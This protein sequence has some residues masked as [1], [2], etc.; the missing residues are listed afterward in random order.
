MKCLLSFA[1]RDVAL[2][3]LCARQSQETE[4]A[5][6][7]SQ[8]RAFMAREDTA[9]EYLSQWKGVAK[10]VL[11]HLLEDKTISVKDTGLVRDT[12]ADINNAGVFNSSKSDTLTEEQISE[13]HALEG[14]IIA[15]FLE[16]YNSIRTRTPP[17]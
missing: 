8:L 6:T 4:A 13:I 7:L 9:R 14:N 5:H 3:A 1:R 10:S 16:V 12:L 2:D 11:E 17:T 15:K